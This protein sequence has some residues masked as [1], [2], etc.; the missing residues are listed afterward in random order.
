MVEFAVH[1]P[2][3]ASIERSELLRRRY[4]RWNPLPGPQGF[5]ALEGLPTFVPKWGKP[6]KFKQ[7]Q[8]GYPRMAGREYIYIYIYT[9]IY[10]WFCGRLRRERVTAVFF[11]QVT[12]QSFEVMGWTTC[13][14][15]KG[16]PRNL[17]GL[18]RF[19]S[20]GVVQ[21]WLEQP[22]SRSRSTCL[23]GLYNTGLYSRRVFL[24]SREIQ[25]TK[26]QQFSN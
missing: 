9:H 4:L 20:P 17:A 13:F 15:R 10:I 18:R 14:H 7:P 25:Q 24:R 2:C 3:W 19:C 22:D 6:P 23:F 26:Q 21:H 5:T 11:L 8:I 1:V 12:E 16:V